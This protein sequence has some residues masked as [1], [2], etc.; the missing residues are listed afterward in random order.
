MTS[1]RPCGADPRLAPSA[2]YPEALEAAAELLRASS[3]VLLLCHDSPDG[4]TLGSAAV[5]YTHLPQSQAAAA[6]A[7]AF[8][9]VFFS[10]CSV[11]LSVCQLIVPQMRAP[12]NGAAVR[13][14][15]PPRKRPPAGR[16]RKTG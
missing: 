14:P 2:P 12:R 3:S 9:F 16:P 1:S 4:D 11:L 10:S 13:N 15:F 5:S 6:A 8:S 7:A